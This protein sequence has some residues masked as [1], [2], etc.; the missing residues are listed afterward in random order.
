MHTVVEPLEGNKVKLSIEVDEQE[1]D[2][3][4]DAAFRKIAREVSIP[5]FRPGKAPRRILESRLGP[6]A[7]RTQAL[8]DALP[9][10]YSQAVLDHDVDAIAAPEIDITSGREGGFVAFEAVVEVRPKLRLVG[11]GGLRVTV[12]DPAVTEADIQ[13]QIDRLRSRFGR[14][15][16]VARPARDGD[17]L[18]V[19]IKTTQAGQ[20]LANLTAD[21]LLYELGSGS[22][23]PELDT[24]LQGARAGDILNFTDRIGDA[25]ADVTVL[26]K[27]VSEKVLPEATDE[28]AAEASE[29]D[30]LEEL[31]A[32]IAK[33]LGALKRVNAFLTLRQGVLDAVVELVAEEPPAPLV[34]AEVRNRAEDLGRRLQAQG[35]TISEYLEA[36]GRSEEELL[37]ELREAAVA[38]VKADLALRAVAEGEGIEPTEDDIEQEVNR[39]ASAAGIKPAQLKRSLER[40]GG[41]SAVRS[42]W[43]KTKALEWLMDHAEIVDS[44]GRPVDRAALEP[45]PESTPR[46]PSEGTEGVDGR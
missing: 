5:G 22:L 27:E 45:T 23:L 16:P 14:L 28:W 2:K 15:T 10:Y 1:F 37:G 13:A 9:A 46:D 6:E 3:A 11:Y 17:H 19:N 35:S 31:K 42:D 39:I 12:P 20:A 32:D 18:S 30:T 41:M 38:A 43:R 24:N 7:G 26:V 4:V 25:S 8:H 29:F 21:D 33:Q 34:D 40:G 36:I 44:E